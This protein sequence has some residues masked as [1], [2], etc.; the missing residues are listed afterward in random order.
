MKI[1]F[2]LIS[3]LYLS[4]VSAQSN[5]KVAPA[6][7][8]YIKFIEEYESKGDV[9]AAP[10]PYQLGYSGYYKQQANKSPKIYPLVY[11]L[12]TAGPGGTSLLTSVKHQLNC[13]A[14]WAFA[15]YGSIESVWKIAGLGD[16]DLSENNL[17]NC[18]GFLPGACQ[19]GHHFMSTAYLVRGHG[20]IYENDDPYQPENDTCN[21]GFTPAAYIPESRYLPEDHNAFKE[22]IMTNGAVYNT[23]R[24]EG[25]SYQWINGHLTYCYQGPNSTTHAIAIVGWDDTITTGCGQ[26][27]WLVKDQYGVNHGE[28]GFYYI[29][30]HDTLVLKYNAIWPINES[31]DSTMN[32]YQ[33]DTIGGWPFVGY[34]DS[35]AYGL[36]KFTAQ[37]DEF[38]TRIGTYTVGF[39]TSLKADIYSTFD[40]IN[41]LGLLYSAPEIQCDYP[42]FWMIDLPEPLIVNAGQDFYIRIRYNSPGEEY[43]LTVEGYNLD[44]TDPHIE[45]GKCWSKEEGGPWEAWG[46]GSG[47]EN[48][49]CIKA[50]SFDITKVSI[51]VLLEGPYNGINMDTVLRTSE[52]FP[53]VQPYAVDP[54]QYLGTE[55]IYS[56]PENVVDWLLVEL[57]E[58]PGTAETAGSA[59]VIARKATLLKADGSVVDIS[60]SDTLEFKISVKDNLFV[61]VYHR[62]HLP[63]MSAYPL[64]KLNDVYSYDF[65]NGDDKAYGELNGH[66][67]LGSGKYGMIAG[68]G[69]QSGI[70]NENDLINIWSNQVGENGYKEADFNL[71]KEV[72]NSDKND[73]CIPN[74]GSATQIPD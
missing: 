44:Y 8:D 33:Y 74:S 13:G 35:V 29:S 72:S 65:T 6:N 28:G 67:H 25:A 9:Y 52:E 4:S 61:V 24:S 41:L 70:V 31:Y 37:N 5:L 20:T 64:A 71:N 69:D 32:I 57:R 50:F 1:V 36:I 43:P 15:T 46:I 27:A 45:T 16:N 53:L 58:T 54:W 49:I 10:S 19:W 66:K 42:G 63:V 7:P 3:L 56:I 59:S 21:G 23:F 12:R 47:F 55:T 60:G 30:Y 62:N 18:H 48:D 34:V 39:G 73:F 14:C 38:L 26:G 2:L 17:K 68:E 22:T 11:D 51:N 40:G